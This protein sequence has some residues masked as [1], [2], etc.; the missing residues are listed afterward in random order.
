MS[1]VSFIGLAWKTY[2]IPTDWTVGVEL[3]RHTLGAVSPTLHVSFFSFPALTQ[4]IGVDARWS[5]HLGSKRIVRGP[6]SLR[7]GFIFDFNYSSQLL[8]C[9][10]MNPSQAGSSVTSSSRITPPSWNT[11]SVLE[12][13]VQEMVTHIPTN[14][15]ESIASSITQIG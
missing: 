3:L 5:P 12:V 13:R 6:R 9:W 8:T 7:Y 1:L 10:H 14:D 11:R 4:W 2:S 15:R